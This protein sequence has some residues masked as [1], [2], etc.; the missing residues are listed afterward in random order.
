MKK[1]IMIG[2]AVA[3]MALSS[4]AMDGWETNFEKAK[5]K[6]KAENKYIL[7]D[8]S[9]SDWCIWC[10]R[11]N[12]EVF[13]QQPFKDF[14]KDNL[15]TVVVDVP[16]NGQVSE[17]TQMLLQQFQV[18]GFPTVY[19]LDPSGKPIEKTGYRRGGPQAYVDYLKRVIEADKK[20]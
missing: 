18:R 3:G 2:L 20:K 4:M 7:L 6:A 17:E 9:G 16:G 15:V 19:I 10:Q 14:A 8:F 11:L 13:S 1:L 12:Q 5:A